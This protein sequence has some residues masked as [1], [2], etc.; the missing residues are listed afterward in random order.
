MARSMMLVDPEEV[1]ASVVAVHIKVGIISAS[2]VC[3]TSFTEVDASVI[4]IPIMK[5]L[6]EAVPVLST[7]KLARECASPI[8]LG[9]KI[10]STAGHRLLVSIVELGNTVVEAIGYIAIGAIAG[11]PTAGQRHEPSYLAGEEHTVVVDT[12]AE[13]FIMAGVAA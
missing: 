13:Y 10:E 8:E 7:A 3:Q 9:E 12:A 5:W 2:Q 4:L 1:L 11:W 6:R